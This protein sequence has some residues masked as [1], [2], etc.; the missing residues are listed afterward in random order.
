MSTYNLTQSIKEQILKHSF[1]KY[2]PAKKEEGVVYVFLIRREGV[3]Y[4]KKQ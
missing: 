4:G 1:N 2:L 3:S